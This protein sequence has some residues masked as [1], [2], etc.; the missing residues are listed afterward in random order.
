MSGWENV[1]PD[2][3]KRA[4]SNLTPVTPSKRRD[5]EDV[6]R[7]QK[8]EIVAPSC[9]QAPTNGNAEDLC[10]YI[11]GIDPGKKTGLAIWDTYREK[12]DAV[13]TLDFWGVHDL[14]KLAYPPALC[15]LVIEDP[16]QNKATFFHRETGA[17]KREKISRNVGANMEHATLLIERFESLGYDVR[18]IKPTKRK[19]SADTFK[20]ETGYDKRT[21]EHARDAARL[22]WDFIPTLQIEARAA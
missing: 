12:Y 19:W 17:K 18:A 6:V 3:R 2:W 10:R 20:R 7:Y 16:K 8:T 9:R 22:A 1:D 11:I 15:V 14:L 5:H 4:K 13:K 21:S